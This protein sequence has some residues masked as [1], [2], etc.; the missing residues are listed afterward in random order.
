MENIRADL[1]QG[2]N[3]WRICTTKELMD[4]SQEIDLITLIK[5]R[6]F[7]LVRTRQQTAG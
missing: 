6:T 1:Y 2:K 7:N 3:I 4:P 5:S